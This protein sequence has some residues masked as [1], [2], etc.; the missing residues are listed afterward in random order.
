[1]CHSENRNGD[2]QNKNR[3]D[4]RN[5]VLENTYGHG[6]KKPLGFVNWGCHSENINGDKQNKKRWR[7][8]NLVLGNGYGDK[9]KKWDS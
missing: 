3:W 4:L 8:R 6:Y 1:M 5:C 2:K 9:H 7:M